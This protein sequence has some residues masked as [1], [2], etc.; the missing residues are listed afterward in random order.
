MDRWQQLGAASRDSRKKKKSKRTTA[1]MDAK[2]KAPTS[3]SSS[4]G[5]GRGF[6]E[7]QEKKT[8]TTLASTP[9]A[10][11]KKKSTWPG[12]GG[13]FRRN[14]PAKK[15]TSSDDSGDEHRLS[16]ALI[17][18]VRLLQP[19]PKPLPKDRYSPGSVGDS[20]SPPPSELSSSTASLSR[21]ERREAILAR[22][23]AR[24]RDG[25]AGGSSSDEQETSTGPRNG[26]SPSP[27]QQRHPRR[28]H[29]NSQESLTSSNGKSRSSR[30]ERYLQR[31][32]R[33]EE[34]FR[35]QSLVSVSNPASPSKC[36]PPVS[37]PTGSWGVVTGHPEPT[38]N[39]RLAM[40]E[41]PV[42]L[43]SNGP[44]SY[45]NQ[46]LSP[47]GRT[48]SALI[49]HGKLT[50]HPVHPPPPPPRNPLKK[51]YLLQ[52]ND[53]ALGQQQQQQ[54]HNPCRPT[55][56][57]FGE[58][59]LNVPQQQQQPP[60]QQERLQ[61]SLHDYQNVDPEGRIILVDTRVS[62][63]TV[64]SVQSTCLT[65][66]VQRRMLNGSASPFYSPQSRH[67]SAFY[68]AVA[69]KSPSPFLQQQQQPEQQERPK[70]PWLA[71]SINS[72][73]S[74]T[75]PVREFWRSKD[76]QAAQPQHP[77]AAP[78]PPTPPKPTAR[79]RLGLSPLNSP[80]TNGSVV[81]ASPHSNLPSPKGAVIVATATSSPSGGACRPFVPPA[82]ST[83]VTPKGNQNKDQHPVR[84]LSQLRPSTDR[85]LEQAICELE[86]IYRSL[87]LDG[88]EDLLD[89][90]E[91]RD[92][93]TAHQQLL[94]RSSI[95]SGSESGGDPLHGPGITS[96]L[97]TM[98]NWSISGSFESLNTTGTT[99]GSGSGR[100]RAPPRR[101]SAV[102]DKVADD[103]ALRRLQ[104]A[105]KSETKEYESGSY[106]LVTPSMAA[107]DELN[108]S[109]NS[110]SGGSGSS[111]EPDIV[112]DDLAVRQV[113]AA[114]LALKKVADPQPPFGIP[115]V[116]LSPVS[117][118]PPTD[119]LHVNVKPEQKALRPLLH[120]TK[121]PDL[122]RDDLAYRQ[123]RKDAGHSYLV[124]TDKLDE[125]LRENNHPNNNSAQS[126]RQK[127]AVR[128]LSANIGQL[129]IRDASRP[130]GGGGVV[131]PN[132]NDEDSE[133]ER[134]IDPNPFDVRAQSLTDLLS[135]DVT[136]YSALAGFNNNNYCKPA[137][138]TPRSVKQRSGLKRVT[139]SCEVEHP[140]LVTITRQVRPEPS[141]VERA[142][143]SSSG[144][145]VTTAEVSKVP[146]LAKL[147][148]KTAL[149]PVGTDNNNEGGS[150]S[151]TKLSAAADEMDHLISDLSEFAASSGTSSWKSNKA[152][153]DSTV[154][155]GGQLAGACRR[156]KPP[157]G[158]L[159]AAAASPE[160]LLPCE[161]DGH[162]WEESPLFQSQPQFN[163]RSA[164]PANSTDSGQVSCCAR[165]VRQILQ[166]QQQGSRSSSGEGREE[167][168]ASAA[169][170]VACPTSPALPDPAAWMHEPLPS[171]TDPEE[172][173]E[174]EVAK[175]PCSPAS[176]PASIIALDTTDDDILL[177]NS[178]SG[179]D[180][181]IDSLPALSCDRAS[182][183][184]SPEEW[185]NSSRQLSSDDEEADEEVE[186]AEKEAE[187]AVLPV[188]VLPTVTDKST[189][190][191]L[192]LPPP[193]GRK[194][195]DGL[196]WLVA[197]QQVFYAGCIL[198]SLLTLCGLDLT[199]CAHL[200][201]ALLALAAVFCEMR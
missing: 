138:K 165:E 75:A 135:D 47:A 108:G 11:K 68:P 8:A 178:S 145:P 109:S 189:A 149:L 124:N 115:N 79:E 141:W 146:G 148:P 92:L 64:Q 111:S 110:R 23:Q 163:F 139:K 129:I 171:C 13:L 12:W 121:Y 87:K 119:Y 142:Q 4:M 88:D 179:S 82:G 71:K 134:Y 58:F 188:V 52:A 185:S 184:S 144:T 150:S 78:P 18:P 155:S 35:S 21:K 100:V 60:Q 6:R 14:K 89:R 197:A 162:D 191:W 187:A 195:P 20:L 164:S 63:P 67:H 131:D 169:Q 46:S 49:T 117:P 168:A 16:K 170:H 113:R 33:D 1:V 65:S 152:E 167:A 154:S 30:T 95:Y 94:N 9:D 127:R 116:L 7:A 90:A 39:P 137:A 192:H 40:G 105:R 99:V 143:L 10:A 5:F 62:N 37:S 93:P 31:R 34:S 59:R 180:D 101:R 104:A 151:S 126:F 194:S 81:V 98:M 172:D 136:S 66:P 74:P 19:P 50:V 85:H 42:L 2:V 199:T 200:L 193:P 125:L 70:P 128:S 72:P 173:A 48:Q 86:D 140:E 57:S 160:V 22:A 196:R 132:R 55:S 15:S 123:L 45:Y 24:R 26:P 73:V 96:D 44:G 107:A 53:P 201:L 147:Y 41:S 120:P 84:E 3:S 183:R 122:V 118:A 28:S 27:G 17:Q 83:P 190:R 166:H 38:V 43:R 102:P 181:G 159:G 76:T 114:S 36:W 186:E 25:D 91:R 176:S 56:F 161:A 103:M 174:E 61:F 198:T 29:H 130:S 69:I 158:P 51:S 54:Q 97:D 175:S 156:D 77:V 182:S 157:T 80:G 106:L 112:L 133:D 32:S 177:V 153:V